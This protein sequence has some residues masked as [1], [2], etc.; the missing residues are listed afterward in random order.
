MSTKEKYD[1]AEDRGNRMS[2]PLRDQER[3]EF[4][5]KSLQDFFQGRAQ[6]VEQFYNGKTR[7]TFEKIS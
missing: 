4:I 5:L 3:M 6:I 7:Y 1:A 2:K